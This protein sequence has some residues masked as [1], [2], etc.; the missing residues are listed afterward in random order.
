MPDKKSKSKKNIIMQIAVVVVL[1]AFAGY[2]ILSVVLVKNDSKNEEM[3]KAVN[4]RTVYSFVKQ[5]DLSFT[6]AKDNFITRINIEIAD[7]DEKR[8]T[9]LMYRDKMEESQGMLFIFDTETPQAF[10]MKNTII[11]LDI[12][13]V[14]SKMQIV[15]IQKN[16]V[17]Y[18]E[19]SLP[20][21]KPAQ[22][23]VEV[24]GGYCDKL[25]IKEGDKI[26]WRRD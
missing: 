22:Y 1:I 4:S 10:W 18:S 13:F 5:G 8:T 7:N 3:D 16:A 11:P 6:D 24:N 12:I 21:E 25:G 17:P 14:N 15:K 19:T 26:A 9:G 20:S 23:V 2:F